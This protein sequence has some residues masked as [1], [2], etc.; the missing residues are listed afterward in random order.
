MGRTEHHN[1]CCS[2]NG[3]SVTLSPPFLVDC[4]AQTD[5]GGGVNSSRP[6]TVPRWARSLDIFTFA[7][8]ARLDIMVKCSPGSQS[9]TQYC[10]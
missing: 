8:L 10:R 4:L 3:D 6:P 7:A 2:S 9:H 1:V 5:D